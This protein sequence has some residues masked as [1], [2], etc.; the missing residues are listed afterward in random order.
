M[1]KVIA[2]EIY[3]LRESN[4]IKSTKLSENCSNCGYTIDFINSYPKVTSS[5][6]NDV[7][8]MSDYRCIVSEK[9]K[10]FCHTNHYDNIQ[11]KKDEQIDGYYQF[12]CLNAI[13]S[14]KGTNKKQAFCHSCGYYR[15]TD[16]FISLQNVQQELPDGFYSAIDS[17]SKDKDKSPTVISPITREKLLKEDITGVYFDKIFIQ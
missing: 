8:I 5:N 13:L 7:E 3:S 1:K 2:Y 15:N 12:H 17:H 14:S 6:L 16:N 11:F 4:S 10:K 9:F